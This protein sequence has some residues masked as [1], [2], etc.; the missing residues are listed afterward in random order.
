MTNLKILKISWLILAIIG[1]GSGIRT[2]TLNIENPLVVFAGSM[3]IIGSMIL[4]IVI[5]MVFKKK[6]K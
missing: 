3:Q 6:E 5:Y 1:L 4:F 2:F